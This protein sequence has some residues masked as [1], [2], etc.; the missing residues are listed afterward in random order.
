MINLNSKQMLGILARPNASIRDR[1]ANKVLSLERAEYQKLAQFQLLILLDCKRSRAFL[2]LNLK[3]VKYL[4]W[5]A[6]DK[7]ML[8]KLSLQ[9]Q[10]WIMIRNLKEELWNRKSAKFWEQI[11]SPTSKPWVPLSRLW[12]MSS[13]AKR[14]L[15]KNVN[16]WTNFLTIKRL[17]D[18]I[19]QR[20][21]FS[22]PTFQTTKLQ[23]R[24]RS[25]K[26]RTT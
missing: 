6:S 2:T 21:S 20:Q 19:R 9:K 8:W 25:R 17:K 3:P 15:Q 24:S 23:S 5:K 13:N 14:K 18:A 11:P 22:R 16:F 1:E 10:Y 4:A 12:K 7:I 26:K